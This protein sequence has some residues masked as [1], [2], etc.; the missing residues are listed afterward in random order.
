MRW[1]F[2]SF[3]FAVSQKLYDISM[4]DNHDNIYYN[5]S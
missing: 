5:I 2:G 3:F 1:F 4:K